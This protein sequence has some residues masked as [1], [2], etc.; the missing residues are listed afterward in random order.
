MLPLLHFQRYINHHMTYQ[1][2]LPLVLSGRV[3]P[4]NERKQ[5]DN[6]ASVHTERLVH[7]AVSI[8]NDWP[9]KTANVSAEKGK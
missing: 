6:P 2:N 3:S 1:H 9:V 5:K 8:G 7:V 4:G